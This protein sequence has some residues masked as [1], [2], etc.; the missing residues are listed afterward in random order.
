MNTQQDAN[1]EFL[2]S[3]LEEREQSAS[4]VLPFGKNPSKLCLV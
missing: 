3:A 2:S 4:V 1:N